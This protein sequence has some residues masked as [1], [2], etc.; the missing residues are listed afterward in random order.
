MTKSETTDVRI[1]VCRR[2]RFKAGSELSGKVNKIT[3]NI[4]QMEKP[5]VDTECLDVDLKWETEAEVS[6]CGAE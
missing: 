2:P 3:I 6:D 5:E 1:K 4:D